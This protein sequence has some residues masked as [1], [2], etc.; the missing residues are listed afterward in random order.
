MN[1]SG[2]NLCPR[3]DQGAER[4]EDSSLRIKDD[5]TDFYD[6]MLFGTQSG[7][8]KINGYKRH[9]PRVFVVGLSA[10]CHSRGPTRAA[11]QVLTVSLFGMRRSQNTRFRGWLPVFIKKHSPTVWTLGPVIPADTFCHIGDIAQCDSL[12]DN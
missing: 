8:L 5:S 11:I 6:P 3:I 10:R 12:S 4:F 1:G 9:S 2:T 7:R